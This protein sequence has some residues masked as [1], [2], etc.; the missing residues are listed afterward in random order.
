MHSAMHPV[1]H[2]VFR[3]ALAKVTLEVYLWMNTARNEEQADVGWLTQI[4]LNGILEQSKKKMSPGDS[5][6]CYVQRSA[7]SLKAP[8]LV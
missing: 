7:Y 6:R 8:L 4:R 5:S 3:E 1:Y 2:W